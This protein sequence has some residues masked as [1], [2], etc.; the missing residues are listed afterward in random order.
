M[1]VLSNSTRKF[2]DRLR[3]ENLSY[4]S[5][6]EGRGTTPD[7]VTVAYFAEKIYDMRITFFFFDAVVQGK[8]SGIENVPIYKRSELGDSI[9]SLY[10]EYKWTE[11]NVDRNNIT[12]KIDTN[13]GTDD[14]VSICCD[15]IE[16]IANVVGKSKGIGKYIY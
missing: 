10:M 7:I 16:K 14:A 12:V 8:I 1:I 3:C 6:E 11:F 4:Y 2:L 13:F 5:I 15:I 9:N